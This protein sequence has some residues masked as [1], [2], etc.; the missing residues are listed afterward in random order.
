L[1]IY[2]GW[3]AVLRYC[4]YL[5]PDIELAIE[6]ETGETLEI[7]YNPKDIEELEPIPDEYIYALK[8]AAAHFA[9]K[10]ELPPLSYAEDSGLEDDELI[11]YIDTYKGNYE[12]ASLIFFSET[13]GVYLPVKELKEP[14]HFEHEDRNIEMCSIGSLYQL[15]EDLEKLKNL[16]KEKPKGEFLEGE[17]WHIELK[18]V[19]TLLEY[20]NRAI[21]KKKPLTLV[22]EEE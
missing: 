15:K 1:R 20:T 8:R 13:L 9:V 11:T 6:K 19:E 17:P 7:D 21:E 10:G 14:L 22:G 16:L 3:G 4:E 5:L 18:A 2:L 12:F